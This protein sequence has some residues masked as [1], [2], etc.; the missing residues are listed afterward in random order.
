MLCLGGSPGSQAATRMDSC[1]EV[2]PNDCCT[3]VTGHT[4]LNCI[5]VLRVSLH[6]GD[7]KKNM[8]Q[9]EPV[10][11]SIVRTWALICGGMS[12][13]LVSIFARILDRFIL[14]LTGSEDMTVTVR[15]DAVVGGQRSVVGSSGARS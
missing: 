1:R 14:S 13:S 9:C 2:R 11:L 3:W 10:R 15:S 4:S 6:I 5:S 7:S 12:K 8:R